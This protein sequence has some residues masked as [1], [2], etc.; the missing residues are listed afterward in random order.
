M[1][2]ISLKFVIVITYFTNCAI[3]KPFEAA[4]F[5]GE[6]LQIVL[7]RMGKTGITKTE[8]KSIY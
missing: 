1:Q 6:N 4:F 3:K 7:K 2:P 5:R 8:T